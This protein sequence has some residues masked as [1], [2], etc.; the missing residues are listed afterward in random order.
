MNFCKGANSFTHH[1]FCIIRKNV[2][3]VPTET[4][5]ASRILWERVLGTTGSLT[6]HTL[7]S[8]AL[9]RHVRCNHQTAYLSPCTPHLHIWGYLH[10]GMLFSLTS[11]FFNVVLS[12]Q[13]MMYWLTSKWIWL[14]ALWVLPLFWTSHSII[15]HCS[16]NGPL[17]KSSNCVITVTVWAF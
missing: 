17:I 6:D 13:G 14:P 11:A 7:R 15:P 5:F 9:Y 8:T 16:S 3:M 1:C 2:K 12:S 4:V 10:L